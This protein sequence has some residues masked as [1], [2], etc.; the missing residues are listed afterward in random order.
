MNKKTEDVVDFGTGYRT[1]TIPTAQIICGKIYAID[2]EQSM[3]NL[4]EQKA[5]EHNLNNVV[6][7]QC[8][9]ISKGTGFNDCTVDFVM[10]FNILHLEKPTD[11]LKETYR[12]LKPN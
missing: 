5:K 9:F 11:L 6:V 2:I 10:L 4:V 3:V 12:I 7:I 8:D 1:F